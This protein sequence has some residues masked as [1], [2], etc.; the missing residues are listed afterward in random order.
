MKIRFKLALILS[1]AVAAVVGASCL[2]FV[3]LQRGSLRRSAAE[4]EQ[5]L[6]ESVERVA[7]ESLLASD[8]LMLLD[9]LRFLRRDRPEARRCRVLLDGEWQEVGGPAAAE[10]EAGTVKRL[11]EAALPD[12]RS[13]VSVELLLS[14]NLLAERE[15]REFALMLRGVGRTGAG[16][17]VL[18]LLLSIPLSWTLTRRI[19]RIRRVLGA[20]SEGRFTESVPDGGSDELAEL[21]RGVNEMSRRLSEL[22][23]MKKLFIASVSHELRSPLEAIDSHAR[24]MSAQ[25]H[26]LDDATRARLE[27]IHKNASRLGHFVSSLLEMSKIER[28]RLDYAP[29]PGEIEPL[30]KDLVLFLAP[31]AA[32]AS[33]TLSCAVEPGLPAFPFDP[34]LIAQVLTNLISNAIKFTPA[35]GRVSVKV[36]READHVVCSVEDSGVGIAAPDLKLIFAPFMRVPNSMHANGTGLGLAISKKIVEMHGGRIAVESSAGRGS[37]FYFELPLASR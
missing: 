4:K 14:T 37:R 2:A 23:E 24:G 25:L 13:R 28:G 33:L 19:V 10:P 21:G 36:A 30:V 35:G 3:E 11:V 5:L 1:A 32:Q 9:Y 31:R 22:D 27:S 34:D 8:P 20:V 6:L 17:A 7:R 15:R 12:G 26:G 29:K 16:L 18:G